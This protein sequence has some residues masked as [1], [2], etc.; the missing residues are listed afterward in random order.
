MILLTG[1]TGKCGG[2]AAAA[3]L[4]REIAVRVLVRDEAKAAK[5]K[6]GGAE[7]VVGDVTQSVDLDRAL[8]GCEKALLLLPN[9]EQQLELEKQFV[10]RARQAGVKHVV[11][12]SSMEAVAG[13][14]SPIPAIHWSSEEHL[15]SSGLAWTLVKP[16]FFMQNLLANAVT[17][18]SMN[19]FFLPMGD[20]KTGMIDCRDVGAVIAE[21][22]AG[23]GHEGQSYQI[24]GPELLSFQDVADRFSQVLGRKIEYVNQ[25]ADAYREQLAKFLTNPWHLDAVCELF[26]GIA[27]GGLE[28]MTDTVRE[29]LGRDPVPLKQFIGDHAAAYQP[30]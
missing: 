18:K 29:L 16:N 4:K 28:H 15:R 20:S 1:A 12:L 27:A 24:T 21:T 14:T 8:A 9:S 3:L 23:T 19:K 17:I 2:P 10:D 30:G 5:L 7:I 26:R 6:A 13:T 22:L 11:K 25:P